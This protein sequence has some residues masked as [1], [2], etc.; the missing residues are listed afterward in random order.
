MKSKC[1]LT[2]CRNPIT[3]AEAKAISPFYDIV[4]GGNDPK[5]LSHLQK[6]MSD[7]GVNVT[8]YC[9]DIQS[10]SSVKDFA[11]F[12]AGDSSVGLLINNS[13]VSSDATCSGEIFDTNA[14]GSIYLEKYFSP[15]QTLYLVPFENDAV[16]EQQFTL[17]SHFLP[18]IYETDAETETYRRKMLAFIY[19]KPT[20]VQGNVAYVISNSIISWCAEQT[21]NNKNA[22]YY[23]SASSPDRASV[24]DFIK[25]FL[26]VA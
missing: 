25:N 1:V 14:M 19:S 11:S 21:S 24:S 5:K 18:S 8:V 10:G 16:K 7:D 9:Y 12:A 15:E 26:T 2:D 13:I 4:I 6:C 17:D 3:S 20:F 22:I 23:Y